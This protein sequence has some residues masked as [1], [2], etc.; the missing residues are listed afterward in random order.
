MINYRAYY[1]VKKGPKNSGRGLPPPLIRAMPE[2]K[3]SLGKGSSSIDAIAI[4]KIWNY[5]WLTHSL[6]RVGAKRCYRIEELLELY[7]IITLFTF[8]PE[9]E[10]A[11]WE[12]ITHSC[13][14]FARL[15]LT[16]T[17]PL[18]TTHFAVFWPWHTYCILSCMHLVCTL[19]KVWLH[20][21]EVEE[22]LL[23]RSHIEDFQGFSKACRVCFC[24]GTTKVPQC[25]NTAVCE[26]Q[27]WKMDERFF[28]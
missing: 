19:A 4:S 15:N 10:K 11:V 14:W 25:R 23:R 8:R 3:H 24:K 13:H 2:S 21:C 12:C 27:S 20:S 7:K 17:G 1:T 16:T 28:Q 5:Q 26:V 6:T 22:K 18:L 9:W